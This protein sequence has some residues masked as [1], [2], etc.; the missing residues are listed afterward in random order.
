VVAL[1]GLAPASGA[2][3]PAPQAP[4]PSL[5]YETSPETRI[6]GEI[7]GDLVRETPHFRI[8]V[9]KGFSP[10]DL[11]WLQVEAEAIHSYLSLRMG[12]ITDEPLSLT[13]RPPDT[14][15][16]PVRGFARW[17]TPVAQAIVFADEKTIRS[18]VLGILAHEV[19]HLFHSRA[20][21]AG[22]SDQNLSEGLAAWGA[23]KYWEEW[24]KASLTDAVRSFKRDGSYLSLSNYFRTE[25]AARSSTGEN[26]LKD[27]DVRYGSWAAFIDF[28]IKRYGMEKFRQLL[29]PLEQSVQGPG[30]LS[31]KPLPIVFGAV[32]SLA[33]PT[34]LPLPP[35][36][37]VYGLTLEELEKAWWEELGTAQ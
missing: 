12:A 27:R 14:R 32:R 1:F 7:S 18:Q 24:Q 33:S 20:L 37:K 35:F 26:C 9:E 2:A 13:F 23:G 25:V 29:G 19:A 34:L 8:Y 30:P 10:V 11:D 6:N 22:S 21:K 5:V 4:L 17:G 16:C 3:V 15:P 28:L 36:Q 31:D